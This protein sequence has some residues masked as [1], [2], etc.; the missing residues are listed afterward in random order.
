MV[1]VAL[2]QI[3]LELDATVAVV[4]EGL[5]RLG[6]SDAPHDLGEALLAVHLG[7]RLEPVGEA[8]LLVVRHV[9]LYVALEVVVIIVLVVVFWLLRLLSGVLLFGSSRLLLNATCGGLLGKTYFT[10][11]QPAANLADL[12][13]EDLVVSHLRYLVQHL[14]VSDRSHLL[15]DLLL[16]ELQLVHV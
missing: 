11:A 1:H 10:I 2:N 12:G 4:L 6:F 7:A 5:T 8:H 16:D 15:G 9:T 3:D 14:G 13:G